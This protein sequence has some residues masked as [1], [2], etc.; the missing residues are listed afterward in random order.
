[1]ENLH[2]SEH[3]VPNCELPLNETTKKEVPFDLKETSDGQKRARLSSISHQKN[4]YDFRMK[5][6]STTPILPSD[7]SEPH[8]LKFF[9][10]L[11]CGI[12]SMGGNSIF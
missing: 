11:F 5:A 6:K 2:M 12:L 9:S 1:M 4:L 7:P 10:F 3:I 8:F